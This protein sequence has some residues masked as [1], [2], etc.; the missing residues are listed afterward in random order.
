MGYLD[1]RVGLEH[2]VAVV[3]GGAGGLGAAV[4][5]DLARA[6]V[7]LAICDKNAAFVERVVAELAP[8]GSQPLAAVV[9]VREADRFHA[10]FHAAVEH[11]GRIDILVNVAGGTFVAN[12]LDTNAKGWDAVIQMNFGWLL[13]SIQLAA[14]QMKAQGDGGSI[15]N[16]T[17]IEAHRAAPRYAV[18]AAMKAAVTSLSRSLAL[19]LGPYGIRVNT[20]AP[21]QTPTEVMPMDYDQRVI[22][23]GIPMGRLGRDQDIGGAALFLASDLSEYITGTTLHP[24]GGVHASGGWFNWPETGYV[25]NPPVSAFGPAG[26]DPA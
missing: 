13:H 2:K 17:S 18:Y 9:D 5:R 21:D 23:T 11:F 3:A 20:I 1:D 22:T 6:G 26:S 10:F 15:I 14:S 25:N 16:I 24:D 12:F 8:L 7:R 4:S 19:E